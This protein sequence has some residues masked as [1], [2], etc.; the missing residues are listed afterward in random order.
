MPADGSGG[1]DGVIEPELVAKG[2]QGCILD[3][4]DHP[5]ESHGTPQEGRDDVGV[6]VVGEAKQEI[7]LLGINL[8]EN[9]RLAGIAKQKAAVHLFGYVVDFVLI[10]LNDHHIMALPDQMTRGDDG[11]QARA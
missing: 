3:S 4:R 7:A 1:D 10:N 2:D 11:G 6:I 9:I 5:A 8:L